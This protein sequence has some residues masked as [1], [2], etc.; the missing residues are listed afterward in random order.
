MATH[1][2][3]GIL[4]EG[5]LVSG[6][7]PSQCH[8]EAKNLPTH[9][10]TRFLASRALLA[11]LMFMLYGISELP[12]ITI[13]TKGKPTFRD[14][15]LPGFSIAYAGNMVGVALTTEGECGL[16]MELQRA[17]RGFNNPHSAGSP[18]FSSNETLWINNQNDPGEAR[19]QLIALRQSVLKLTGD[20]LN[21]DPRELQ[22]IPVA[23]RLKCAHVA[24]VEAICDA[25]DVLVW[26]VAVS[27]A[28]EKLKVWEFDSQQGW[29]ILPDIQTRANAPTGRLMRFAQ[30]S[31]VKS[32]THS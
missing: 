2:A 31:T 5:H 11:E 19:A 24:Q 21:D 16:D 32:C 18:V 25:E 7:L 12:E 23:G 17:I 6:R 29:K 27:P 20:V 28:I 13:E 22:L 10:R 9:R 1:F 15:N 14:R 30:L 4:T 3:R 26:S 8:I